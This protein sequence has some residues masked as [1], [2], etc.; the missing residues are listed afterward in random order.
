MDQALEP[1]GGRFA[2]ELK[3]EIEERDLGSRRLAHTPIWG[4]APE[5]FCLP[6]LLSGSL[7]SPP[8]EAQVV[9]YHH[10]S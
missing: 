5:M 6:R 3:P 7:L 10:Y 2:P 9:V 8:R 4:V 1:D